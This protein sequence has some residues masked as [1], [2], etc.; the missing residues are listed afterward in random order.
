MIR[1]ND[2]EDLSGFQGVARGYW[3][4]RKLFPGTNSLWFKNND[5]S[6][7]LRGAHVMLLCL[8]GDHISGGLILVFFE[9]TADS[10]LLFRE[11]LRS[12]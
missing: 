3:N 8:R 2:S 6:D 10:F 1:L 4:S 12:V 9:F 5:T 11:K 7:I